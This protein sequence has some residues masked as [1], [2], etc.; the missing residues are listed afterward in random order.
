MEK[1]KVMLTEIKMLERLTKLGSSPLPPKYSDFKSIKMHFFFL[2]FVLQFFIIELTHI[3]WLLS[4]FYVVCLDKHIGA[5]SSDD[6][7]SLSRTC[8]VMKVLP[9]LSQMLL[10][11]P[12]WVAHCWLT[13]S[14]NCPLWKALLCHPPACTGPLH[15]GTL[16]QAGTLSL[17]ISLFCTSFEMRGPS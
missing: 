1:K 11:G 7:N 9:G 3:F 2:I 17:C 12:W 4:N 14:V 6:N 13:L 10:L 15:L 5:M 16:C 8:T